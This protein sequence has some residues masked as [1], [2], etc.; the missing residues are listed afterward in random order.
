MPVEP[1]FALCNFAHN[2]ALFEAAAL[3]DFFECDILVINLYIVSKVT[4]KQNCVAKTQNWK[5]Y[6]KDNLAF[7]KQA[8]KQ[9][10]KRWAL[11]SNGQQIITTES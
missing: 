10:N 1:N 4:L 2:L 11:L 6:S 8:T 5:T 7:A 9:A 3:R